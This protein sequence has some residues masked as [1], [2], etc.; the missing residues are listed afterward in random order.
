MTVHRFRR[1]DYSDELAT[2]LERLDEAESALR[3]FAGQLSSVRKVYAAARTISSGAR[4]MLE[5]N[6]AELE[7]E[8]GLAESEV[9]HWKEILEDLK[10]RAAH[11]Q[12]RRRT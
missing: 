4:E 3:L 9:S 12:T 8:V 2:V 1:P 10:G 6:I 7:G 11:P 5:Q